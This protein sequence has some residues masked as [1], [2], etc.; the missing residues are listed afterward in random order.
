MTTSPPFLF[1]FEGA[2]SRN[3]FSPCGRPIDSTRI[4]DCATRV[5]FLF[6][7]VRSRDGA[8][9]MGF[10]LFFFFVPNSS[11]QPVCPRVRVPFFFSWPSRRAYPFLFFFSVSR[12]RQK[13][14]VRSTSPLFSLWGFPFNSPRGTRRQTGASLSFSS[15]RG[16]RFPFFLLYRR[17]DGRGMPAPSFSW[18]SLFQPTEERK[19]KVTPFS[20][21]SPL[22]QWTPLLP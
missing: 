9:R 5:V 18:R 4:V 1:F 21:F 14:V 8:E 17:E 3:R 12:R 13:R 11:T 15:S 6:L 20:F 16:R 22:P 2:A 10:S 19:D 7:Q